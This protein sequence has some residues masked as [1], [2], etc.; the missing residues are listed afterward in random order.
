MPDYVMDVSLTSGDRERLA[1]HRSDVKRLD[2]KMGACNFENIDLGEG[3]SVNIADLH[4]HY[5]MTLQVNG[6]RDGIS[7]CGIMALR[8]RASFVFSEEEEGLLIPTQ[9]CGFHYRGESATFQVPCG[10][11]TVTF[12]VTLPRDTFLRYL[13]DDAPPGV[14]RLLDASTAHRIIP[15]SVS[16]QMLG[17]ISG[18]VAP[19][20][21]GSLRR[22]QIE[23]AALLFTAYLASAME[24]SLGTTPATLGPGERAAAQAAYEL[25]CANI[26]EPPRLSEL[27]SGA[28]MTERKLTQAFRELYGG[29][30]FE[31]LRNKRLEMAREMLEQGELAIKEIAF[32]VGYSHV[33]NFSSAFA[34]HFGAPPA[35]Y[36]KRLK[37]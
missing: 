29:T 8:G 3:G 37:P 33:S 4:P 35:T 25:L 7:I 34:A 9:G 15:F 31:V 19:G 21:T 20:L 10:E 32:T 26:G 27:A 11:Q 28:K 1:I 23:G 18:A 6:R 22:T 5:D 2:L 14:M 16:Q 17:A 30:V 36:A 24:R 12:G 13:G